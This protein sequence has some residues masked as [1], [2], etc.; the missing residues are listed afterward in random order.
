M[1]DIG[2]NIRIIP[3]GGVEEVGKNMTA[4]EFG[5]DIIIVD[6][7]FQF[8]EDDTPGIDYILPN[9]KYLED[10]KGKIRGV[11]ITHGHLDHIGGIPYLMDKIGN[12][13]IY[14]RNF[15]ALMVKKRQEEFPHLPALDIRIVESGNRI[16]LGN[17]MV[18]FFAVTHAIPDSMGIIFETP[19]GDI[20]HTG[21]LRLDHDEGKVSEIEEDIYASFKN[22]NVL[23]L[24]TD[25]TNAENPG[26][27]ISE[28][29]VYRNIEEIIK[30]AKGRLILS[31]FASQV[32]RMLK[33]IELSEK[34]GKKIVIE[35]RSMKTN[36][37]VTKAAGLLKIGKESI[38]TVEQ[39]NDYPETKIV[40]LVT[41]AQGEEFAALMRIANKSHKYIRLT[42]RDTILMSSSIVPG[43]ERSVQKLKDNLS[44]QGAHIIHYK[45]SDIHSSGH[46]NGEE[47][48]WIHAKIHPKFFIPIHGYHYMHRV[49]ADIARRLIPES[50]II[51][52]DNGMVIE[53]Q[54]KGEKIV[55]LKEGAPKNIIMVDGFSVGGI[56]EVVIR[57]RQT[58]AQD[59]IFMVVVSFDSQ[60]G[61]LRKSP[62]LI[63]RGFVYLKESQ[64][65]LHQTRNI[66]KKTVEDTTHGMNPINF[67]YVKANVTDAVERFLFQ[68]TAKRP[69]VIPVLI[70][71]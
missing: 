27:S 7:G 16:K 8:S 34:Y 21:D 43:N 53:I 50:N 25:S 30:N 49:H 56:Q 28:K 64:E 60:T 69:I 55:A 33:M 41:G 24:L 39:M 35:G 26:F 4:F 71:V 42:P 32:E 36:I 22:R 45:T 20:V 19:Y 12:P 2:E 61:K 59:G 31:T 5:N 57:D 46:A 23:A 9:T 17:M 67:D 66:V 3:L 14:A 51:I 6:M 1:P 70:G 38:I 15:T 44:R 62:D 47:L 52:P 10:R 58:L 65:L 18:G 29:V 11:L 48:A 63:S 37:E 13:P 68:K 40:A 54:N